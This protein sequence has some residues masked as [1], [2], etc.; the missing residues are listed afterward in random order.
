LL[1]GELW[2]IPMLPQQQLPTTDDTDPETDSP[3]DP[4]PGDPKPGDPSP[5]PKDGDPAPGSGPGDKPSNA[6]INSS[7][8]KTWGHTFSVHGSQIKAEVFENIARP[9]PNHLPK[10]LP[11]QAKGQWTSNDDAAAHI[12]KIWKSLK[13]GYNQI[14]IDPKLG[15]VYR[16]SGKGNEVEVVPS[17]RAVVIVN[18][19]GSVKTAY[20]LDPK[21]PD[22]K[23][24]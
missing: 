6:L 9:D 12:N 1:D 8:P 13:V 5:I 11:G 19:D 22:Y 24:K 4:K 15:N 18:P 2:Q 23:T 20:P 16:P 14:D 3:S 7:R 17:D 21:D 10:P